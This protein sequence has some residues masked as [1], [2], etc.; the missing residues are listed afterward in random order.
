[1]MLAKFAVSTAFAA[2]LAILGAGGAMAQTFKMSHVLSKES[3]WGIAMAAFAEEVGKRTQGRIKIEHEPSVQSGEQAIAE[4][5]QIGTHDFALISTGSMGKIVPDIQ[6]LD[7]MYLFR[8][9]AHA[10]AVLDGPI[11]QELLDAFT[12][13]GMAALC[14]TENGFRHLT[15][16]ARPVK[17][18]EDVKGLKIRLQQSE[19][20]KLAFK[21]LGAEPMPMA[22]N[23][24]YDAMQQ[25]IVDGQENSIALILSSGYANVQKHLTLSRHIFTPAV[26]LASDALWK[27]LPAEDQKAI[28]EAAAAANKVLRDEGDRMER[29]GIAALQKAGMQVVTEIDRKAFEAALAPAYGEFAK[30]FGQEKIDRIRSFK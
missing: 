17:A 1:M 30:Q 24:A 11:G 21:T 16:S 2:A 6:I 4:G 7:I 29:E 27:S 12:P 26:I 18:P 14:W 20:H 5:L 23:K 19:I 22:F 8:D 25:G 3:H 15:N 10:R 13:H 28:R 9:A